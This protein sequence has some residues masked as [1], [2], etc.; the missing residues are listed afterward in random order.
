[1]L[2]SFDSGIAQPLRQTRAENVRSLRFFYSSFVRFLCQNSAEFGES[3]QPST[4][5]GW[6][7]LKSESIAS[8]EM[9]NRVFFRTLAR[10]SLDVLW[11]HDS[12]RGRGQILNLLTFLLA[13]RMYFFP[14][15]LTSYSV[16]MFCSGQL[17]ARRS[18]G[19]SDG[20]REKK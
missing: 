10:C 6:C 1:M 9:C 15:S 19:Q 20:Q 12:V 13:G 4:P 5:N 17:R 11:I 7:T 2:K 8:F 18:S 3:R 16:S 14:N